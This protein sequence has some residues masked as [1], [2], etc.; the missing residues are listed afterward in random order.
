MNTPPEIRAQAITGP[1]T[2]SRPYTDR[3]LR[4]PQCAFHNDAE[5]IAQTIREYG[6]ER[7]EQ[8]AGIPDR[9]YGMSLMSMLIRELKDG[10]G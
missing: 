5:T 7:L 2:C 1:C 4:D 6:D 8:A 9:Y 3:G 10:D